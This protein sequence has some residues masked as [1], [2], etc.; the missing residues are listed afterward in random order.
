MLNRSV[1]RLSRCLPLGLIFC[2]SLP[3]QMPV[4]GTIRGN[5]V[6]PSGHA[7]ANAKVTLTSVSTSESRNAVANEL[8]VFTLAAVQPDTYNLRVEASGFKAYAR[9]RLVVSANERVAVCDLMLQVGD[10]TE[11]ISVASA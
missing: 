10:V 3:A 4:T 11:T 7:V 9:G 1:R 2:W 6:E 5:V 8:G